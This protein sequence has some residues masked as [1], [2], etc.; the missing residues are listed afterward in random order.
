MSVQ[1]VCAGTLDTF[2][3]YVWAVKTGR[4]LEVLAA[5]EGPI[6][7]LAF[8]PTQSLL[9]SCSWDFTVRTWDVFRWAFCCL[10][11]TLHMCCLLEV[12]EAHEGTI[13]P[14]AFFPNAEPAGL[15]QLGLHRAHLGRLQ[16]C[17]SMLDFPTAAVLLAEGAG[18]NDAN[19]GR[20]ASVP[21]LPTR[22]CPPGTCTW[23]QLCSHT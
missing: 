1:V 16:V 15:L 2:Q 9:A 7:Q 22:S 4:L 12:L 11:G 14:L 5:H 3:I 10:V 8:S 19:E 13:A 23:S 18:S 21:P 20:R 6:A 17:S